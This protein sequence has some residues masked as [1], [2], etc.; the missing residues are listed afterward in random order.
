MIS[1]GE[2]IGMEVRCGLYV[3]VER[4][5]QILNLTFSGEREPQIPPRML[6]LTRARSVWL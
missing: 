3:D 5:I 6:R 1:S 4:E 2:G